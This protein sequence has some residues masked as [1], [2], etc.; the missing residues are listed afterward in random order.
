MRCGRWGRKVTDGILGD[1]GPS[2]TSHYKPGDG[3]TEVVS[4][5]VPS[6]SVTC[7]WR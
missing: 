2:V 4:S 3:M 6:P 1:S 5:P 7:N